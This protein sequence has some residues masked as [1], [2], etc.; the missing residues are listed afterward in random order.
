MT[1]QSIRA[2]GALP[3]VRGALLAGM[4]AALAVAAHT[5]GGGMP[6]DAGLTVLLTLGVAAVGTAL[7]GP[8]RGPW[9]I[10]LA[11]GASHLGIHLMLSLSA[12]A[13]LVPDR[14]VNVWLMAGGH[15]LAVLLA[16]AVLTTAEAALFAVV[17]ACVTVLP[18]WLTVPVVG[19]IELPAPFPAE[20]GHVPVSRLLD[21]LLSRSCARRGP[22]PA[23][24]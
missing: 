15:V 12:S 7:A 4:S 19:P 9:A 3:A 6:P 20:A 2:R 14:P 1:G 8:Q 23:W 16:A 22:P 11:V 24:C 13:E 10:L 18:R 17:A 5:I 21:V